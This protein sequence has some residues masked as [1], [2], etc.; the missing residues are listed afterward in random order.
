MAYREELD[1]DKLTKW[2]KDLINMID[3]NIAIWLEDLEQWKSI[4]LSEAR[5]SLLNNLENNNLFS[6][7]ENIWVIA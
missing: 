3:R 2:E 1:F 7:N 4:S 5:K 6:K